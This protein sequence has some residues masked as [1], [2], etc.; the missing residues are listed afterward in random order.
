[1]PNGSSKFAPFAVFRKLASKAPNVSHSPPPR[2]NSSNF[3]QSHEQPL[4]KV[5]GHVHFSPLSG[6]VAGSLTTG[7]AGISHFREEHEEID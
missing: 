1:M 3:D 5:G 6:D 7:G 4:A 2:K